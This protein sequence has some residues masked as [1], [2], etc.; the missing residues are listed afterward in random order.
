M[1][2]RSKI[3]GASGAWRNFYL[4]AVISILL[5]P[6]LPAQDSLHLLSSAVEDL[7]KRVSPSVVQVQVT[8]YGAVGGEGG[9]EGGVVISRQRS[10][11]SGVIVDPDGY[12]VTNAHVVKGAQRIQVVVP[13]LN[14][15]LPPIRSLNSRGRTID[16]RLVGLSEETD[17]AVLRIQ[18]HGLQAIPIANYDKLHQGEMVFAFGNPEG[19]QNSVTMGLVS[20]V[21]RQPDPDS[22]MIFI[23]TDASINPGNSGGPLVDVNGEL[24]G[25]NTY[26]LS[27]SG[28]NEGLGFAIPSAV[29]GFAYPQLRKYGHIHRGEIGVSV[30]TITA[31]MATVLNLPRDYGVI[32][33]DVLPG[34]PAEK[35][36]LRLQDIIGSVDGRPVE[37]LPLFTYALFI[38][39]PG[40]KVKL[41]VLRGSERVQM[42][43]PV[44]ETPHDVDQLVSLADPEKNVVAKLGILGIEIDS[45]IAA[46]LPAL[47]QSSGVIVAARATGA[48]G[49]ENSLTPG[50]VIHAL[51]GSP[52]TSLLGLRS[53]L[54]T[55]KPDSPVVLQI[56]RDGR[57]QYVSFQL[58]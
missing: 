51:N 56:E 7:V 30:Q 43:V 16:A 11:G 58:E 21:A 44:V 27:Q 19:L 42:Q 25:I 36:G 14:T 48:G 23:Q 10:I 49:A 37:S 8:A 57:L 28:G 45:K 50:D 55:L 32:V 17:I 53:G 22:P 31:N 38:H 41:N 54:D 18:A 1:Q 39:G 6:E 5:A 52:I 34:S 29:V 12:I 15:E 47:R 9:G 40:D 26:I 2:H 13:S 24:V 46:M 20:A 4:L 3:G 33:S 35:A